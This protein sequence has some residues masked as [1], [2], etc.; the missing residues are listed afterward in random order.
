MTWHTEFNSALPTSTFLHQDAHDVTVQCYFRLL[1]GKPNGC[2]HSTTTTNRSR[3]MTKSFIEYKRQL[4]APLLSKPS[5][6]RANQ[7][8]SITIPES[9]LTRSSR[10]PSFKE[11]ECHTGWYELQRLKNEVSTNRL[12]HLKH[13]HM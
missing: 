13:K 1:D 3:Y 6:H 9:A 5:S 7:P 10:Q 4:P 2:F 12:K 8:S 11:A